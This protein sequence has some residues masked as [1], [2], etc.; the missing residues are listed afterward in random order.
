MMNL[1]LYSNNVICLTFITVFLKRNIRIF[2]GIALG[3]RLGDWG[4]ESRK[5]LGI[6]LFTTACG[7]AL[8]PTQPPVQ[9]APGALSLRVKRPGREADHSLSSSAEVKNAWNYTS[10]PQ[11]A[12]IA[13]GNCLL[14]LVRKHICEQNFSLMKLN[15]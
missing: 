1:E 8:G 5:E 13:E 9:W 4:L 12:S 14:N 10:T 6:L 11:Y 3:Y 2:S 15:K 7:S